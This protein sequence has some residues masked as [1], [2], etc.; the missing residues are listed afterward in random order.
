[1][2]YTQPDLFAQDGN[3]RNTLTE[4]WRTAIRARLETRLAQLEAEPAFPWKNPLDAVHEEN[5]FEHDTRLLGAEGTALWA[6]FD[7]EMDRLYA[8][9]PGADGPN[10]EAAE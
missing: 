7:R 2:G 9:Q 4:E 5:R 3:E 10:G 1:M 6:R 8:A